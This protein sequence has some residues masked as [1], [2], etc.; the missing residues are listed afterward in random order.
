MIQS[1]P[2][3]LALPALL[4]AVLAGCS[5][6]P[7]MDG[8]GAPVTSVDDTS[9]GSYSAVEYFGANTDI[10]REGGIPE[11]DEFEED[12]YGEG[13]Y[14]ADG[15]AAQTQDPNAALDIRTIYFDYD[16]S[17]IRGDFRNAVIAHG[18]ALASNPNLSLTVEGHCDERGSREYNIALGERRANTVKRLLLAQGAMER[19]IVTISYG[20]ER[21]SVLGSN[22]QA[23]AR[24]RRAE[25][26]Y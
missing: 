24:N 4:L 19:Q 23:W 10:A 15:S 12:G 5:S 21:P 6:S 16:S 14:Y 20:E 7:T 25:L 26:I 8:P 13:S 11:G 17:E 22:E 2:V 1:P 3:K 9:T 18:M